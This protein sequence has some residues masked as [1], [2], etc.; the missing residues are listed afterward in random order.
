M[1]A[2]QVVMKNPTSISKTASA[3]I[4]PMMIVELLHSGKHTLLIWE[5]DGFL[6]DPMCDA[7]E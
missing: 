1:L 4:A 5:A 7:A 2:E 3:R 6:P